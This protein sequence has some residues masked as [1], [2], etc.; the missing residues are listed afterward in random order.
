MPLTAKGE[1]IKE[2]MV[3]EHGEKAGTSEF[4]ASKN[5]GTIS[6]VD[7]PNTATSGPTPPRASQ[8]MIKNPPKNAT[9]AEKATAWAEMIARRS[10]PKKDS[11]GPPPPSGPTEEPAVMPPQNISPFGAS[12][13]PQDC[14]E[15]DPFTKQ[16]D[17]QADGNSPMGRLPQ[18]MSFASMKNWKAF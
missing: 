13:G 16:H 10:Q 12:S 1:E 5:A 18:S 2:N 11:E 3:K 15:G 7:G 8:E 17:F 4:Y 6:G 14:T 9:E